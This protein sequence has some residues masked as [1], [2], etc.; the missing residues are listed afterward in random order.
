MNAVHFLYYYYKCS[1]TIWLL[2]QELCKDNPGEPP[3]YLTPIRKNGLPHTTA[4][5]WPPTSGIKHLQALSLPIHEF[6]PI[7][8]CWASCWQ[9]TR[10][11][12]PHDSRVKHFRLQFFR[13]LVSHN[14][15]EDTLLVNRKWQF[16]VDDFPAFPFGGIWT[17]CSLEGTIQVTNIYDPDI[18]PLF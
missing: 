12:N 14:Q 5:T 16:W 13:G 15:N 2:C 11:T 8:L 1:Y 17:T 3:C 10:N 4:A 18:N 9:T 6:W 7:C